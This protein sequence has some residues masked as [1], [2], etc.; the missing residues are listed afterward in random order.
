MGSSIHATR[1]KPCGGMHPSHLIGFHDFS[2]GVMREVGGKIRRSDDSAFLRFESP[3]TYR[4][5]T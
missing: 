5:E 3:E 2:V 4:C 1:L